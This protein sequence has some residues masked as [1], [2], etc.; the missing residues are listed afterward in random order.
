MAIARAIIN[1]QFREERGINPD[2]PGFA[3][4]AKLEAEKLYLEMIEE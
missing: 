4:W 3:G 2:L 1:K